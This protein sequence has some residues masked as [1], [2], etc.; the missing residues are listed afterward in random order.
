M[1]KLIAALL[2]AA[3]CVLALAGCGGSSSAPAAQA[4]KNVTLKIGFQANTS[5]NE[6]KAAELMAEKAKEY[7]NGTITVEIYPGGQLGDD[8]AM[9]GP[10]MWWC[11][12]KAAASKIPSR[13]GLRR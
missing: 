10:L 11:L 9:T 6:Y 3:T 2:I 1:K 5:S 13:N 12:T 7:S 4:E 8:R